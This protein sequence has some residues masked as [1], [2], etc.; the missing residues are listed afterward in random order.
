MEQRY[1]V[2]ALPLINATL[3][4]GGLQKCAVVDGH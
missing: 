2:T 3:M 4:I 1:L